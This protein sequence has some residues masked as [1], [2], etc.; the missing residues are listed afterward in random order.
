MDIYNAV[1]FDFDGTLLDSYPTGLKQVEILAEQEGFVI[2]P[3]I[4]DTMH[5]S[6]GQ[7][8]VTYLQEVFGVDRERAKIL[9]RRWQRME[10]TEQPPLI[11]GAEET[12]DWL[13]EEGYLL[14]MLTSR[15]RLT[16]LSL[17]E[18]AGLNNHFA[19]ITAHEDTRHHKPDER[20]FA[21]V[22]RELKK[23]GILK[24]QCLFVGDT[25]HDIEAGRNAG[26]KTLVVETGPYRHGHHLTHPMPEKSIIASVEKLPDWLKSAREIIRTDDE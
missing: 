5:R 16:V 9:F 3:E 13:R 2:T 7:T 11:R 22:F 6:W 19:H 23:H 12:L 24:N 20:A 26:I 25:A 8:S 10:I 15:D 1:V 14:C 18:H 4:R 17:L 21:G